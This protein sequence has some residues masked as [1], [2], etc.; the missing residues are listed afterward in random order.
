MEIGQIKMAF[1]GFSKERD[2]VFDKLDSVVGKFRNHDSKKH[3][4]NKQLTELIVSDK[5]EILVKRLS[6]GSRIMIN[7]MGIMT[8]PYRRQ[9][10]YHMEAKDVL[11]FLLEHKT[12]AEVTRRIVKN[13]IVKM[14]V[15][16]FLKACVPLLKFY[17]AW[18]EYE[19]VKGLC[20][21]DVE[22]K[23]GDREHIKQMCLKS[24]SIFL[25]TQRDSVKQILEGKSYRYVTMT[26]TEMEFDNA[27]L[28]LKY[29]DKINER[30]GAIEKRF[31][32]PVNDMLDAI[33]EIR[34]T[35]APVLTLK[36][37]V[38]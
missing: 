20:V 36:A 7:R 11:S 6:D 15:E 1:D 29:Y 32:K 23:G 13:P 4:I 5:G 8:I 25:Y 30:I 27:Y 28:F 26:K 17:D 35:L 22:E 2:A 24:D 18:E 10:G 12:D 31:D 16:C 19:T 21:I 33:E 34:I 38:E 37:I 14:Q 3:F 9:I